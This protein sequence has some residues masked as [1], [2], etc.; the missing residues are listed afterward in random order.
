MWEDDAPLGVLSVG[1]RVADDVLEED[2]EH[3]TGLLIDETGD[4]LH[5]TTTCETADSGL[6]DTLDVVAENLAV[7]LSAALAEPLK[8][9][10]AQIRIE[11]VSSRTNLATLSTARH[12]DISRVVERFKSNCEVDDADVEVCFAR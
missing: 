9:K 3:T 4:T 1:D 2:L 5:T 6:G 11:L 8:Y 12:I 7:K 10:S